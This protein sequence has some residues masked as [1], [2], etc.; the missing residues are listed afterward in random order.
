MEDR[1]REFYRL[2]TQNLSDSSWLLFTVVE[3]DGQPIAMHYGFD[4]C[5]VVTWYK[6]SFDPTFAAHSPGLVLLRH[7]IEYA[8]TRRRREL[9]FTWGDEPFKARFTNHVRRTIH[10]QIYRDSVRYNLDRANR[11]LRSVARR[12]TTT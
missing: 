12:A 8:A 7:L 2:L 11:L 6:P 10:L 9:D 3:L 5:G 4:F 1:N